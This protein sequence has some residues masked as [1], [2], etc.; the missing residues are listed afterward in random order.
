MFSLLLLPSSIAP[1]TTGIGN[2]VNTITN[3]YPDRLRWLAS[4][5]DAFI[6]ICQLA[7]FLTGRYKLRH[8]KA[9]AVPESNKVQLQRLPLAFLDFYSI[10]STPVTVGVEYYSLNVAEAFPA[11]ICIVSP[12]TR[13]YISNENSQ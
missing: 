1:I 10:L 8:K 4:C 2:G 13:E 6:A 3:E 5:F 9:P 11:C 12:L 7:S